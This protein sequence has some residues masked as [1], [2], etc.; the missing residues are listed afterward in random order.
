[1]RFLFGIGLIL[2]IIPSLS[3]AAFEEMDP[4][5]RPMAMGSAFCG[6]PDDC[7]SI[8]VNPAGLPLIPSFQVGVFD[9]KPYGMNELTHSS[10]SLAKSTPFGAMG[11]HLSAFG[12]DPY[13]EITALV[14]CGY[15]VG[16]LSVGGNVKLMRLKI[17]EY[18][19]SNSWGVDLGLWGKVRDGLGLGVSAVNLNAPQLAGD[20]LPSFLT[21]GFALSPAEGAILCG[22]LREKLGHGL[23][24]RLGVEYAPGSHLAIRSGFRTN[25]PSFTFGAGLRWGGFEFSYGGRTHTTLGLTHGVSLLY[26]LKPRS[27]LG[28]LGLSE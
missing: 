12:R 17:S 25:P 3:S 10:L 18:G 15:P 1:M 19:S 26:S 11:I 13:Q 28:V 9:T 6:L 23:E 27:G 2:G 21:A 4:S 24:S 7:Y 5:A 20:K 14:G 16:R 8:T 22:D